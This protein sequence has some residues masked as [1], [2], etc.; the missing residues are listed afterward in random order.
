MRKFWVNKLVLFHH[1]LDICNRKPA[2]ANS[3]IL[4]ER[5]LP[6]ANTSENL[7]ELSHLVMI[8]MAVMYFLQIKTKAKPHFKLALSRLQIGL[9]F[10]NMTTSA[11]APMAWAEFL[12]R[13]T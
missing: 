10:L 7:Q 2:A 8:V 13:R 11:R 5:K 4:I 6:I 1:I 3:Q 9:A 12:I